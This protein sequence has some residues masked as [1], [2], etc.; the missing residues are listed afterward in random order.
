MQLVRQ[1]TKN[2][3]KKLVSGDSETSENIPAGGNSAL[4]QS[5][6]SSTSL[7]NTDSKTLA[8]SSSRAPLSMSQPATREGA[9]PWAN[10]SVKPSPP[11][12]WTPE[13]DAANRAKGW[14]IN[15]QYMPPASPIQRER[16]QPVEQPFVNSLSPNSS[17]LSSAV[18]AAM[19]NVDKALYDMQNREIERLRSKLEASERELSRSKEELL[20]EE[21]RRR[22]LEERYQNLEKKSRASQAY[23]SFQPNLPN[24]DS[25]SGELTL[26]QQQLESAKQEKQL[27]TFK[28][29]EV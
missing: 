8:G 1:P 23:P 10:S 26:L 13:N 7:S 20:K 27:E 5:K 16:S 19:S 18:E 6:I 12:L 22:D 3:K 4:L 15:G 11:V 29:I 28:R 17:A 9:G 2:E 24:S 25:K 14:P 21:A